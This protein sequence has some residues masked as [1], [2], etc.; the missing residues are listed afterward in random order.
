MRAP[1]Q[2]AVIG[3]GWAGIA[4]AIHLTRANRAVRLIDAAP[5]AGGRARRITLE[6]THPRHGRQPIELDNGQHLLLGAY[7]EVLDL[8]RL[9]GGAEAAR[10]ERYPMRF[11]G[12][13]GLLLERPAFERGGPAGTLLAPLSSL[14]ALL[15]ARGLSAG[16]R[17]AMLRALLWLRVA[18]WRVPPGVVTV[19][20]WFR[21]ARQPAEL[22]DRVWRPLVISALNTPTDRACA[23]T[24]L[25]VIRDSLGANPAASDFILARRTLGDLFVDPGIAW[26]RAHGAEV[27]LRCDVRR[28]VR[29]ADRRYRV[30][31]GARTSA[32]PL[33]LECDEVVIATPPYATARLLDGLA[34]REL[35]ATLGRFD[36]LPIT[37]AYLGWPEDPVGLEPPG[38]T[39]SIG[40]RELPGMLALRDDPA[41]QRHAQWFFDRGRHGPWRIAALVLSD[42]RAARELGDSRLADALIRQLVHELDLPAPAQLSLIHEKRATIACTPDRPRV[43]ADAAWEAL[44]GIALAGDYVYADYPATLEGAVR[45]GRLAAEAIVAG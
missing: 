36:Y 3:A 12:S 35:V 17:W 34:S 20:D 31:G 40:S 21:Q 24:F 9:T 27:S 39:A 7:T 28:I 25:R 30:L 14:L 4:A 44:P 33:E 18:G 45:S 41:A 10:M 29:G 2:V 5:Q 22:V 6:W 1:A 16:A 8:L 37:T 43:A 38:A 19:D 11:A 23:A 42:S 32:A 13:G 15:R 26:L